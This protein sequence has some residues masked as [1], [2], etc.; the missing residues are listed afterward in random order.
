MEPR[1]PTRRTPDPERP[2]APSPLMPM[3]HREAGR[4]PSL[5]PMVLA[6]VVLVA[7]ALLAACQP[8]AASLAPERWDLSE[9]AETDYY[10]LLLQDA[11]TSQNATVGRFALEQLLE[12]DPSPDIYREGAEFLWKIGDEAA[13]RDLLERGLAKSPRNTE[14]QILLAQVHLTERRY[15]EAVDAI[16]GF[17]AANPEE[18]ELRRRLAT[19]LLQENRHKET[20]QVFETMAPSAY[21]TELKH[22][23]ARALSGVKRHAE[24]RV[25]LEEV[26]AAEPEFAEAHAELAFVLEEQGDLEAAAAQYARLLEFGEPNPELV[27]RLVELNL[28]LDREPRAREYIFESPPELAFYFPAL[29]AYVEAE[30]YEDAKTIVLELLKRAPD[31]NEL[32]FVHGVILFEGFQDAAGAAEALSKVE[33]G[34]AFHDRARRFEVQ[35]LFE[36]GQVEEALALGEQNRLDNEDDHEYWLAQARLLHGADR[37]AEAVA[38]AEKAVERWPRETDVLFTY[39]SLLDAAGDKSQAMEV[40]EVVITLDEDH[41]DA[42][43]YIGYTLA[44][45]GE[46]L[47]RALELIARAVALEPENGYILDSL[48]WV[49]YRI[50]NLDKAWELIQRSVTMAKDDPIIWE[51]YGDIAR[52]KNLPD[53]AAH[54]YRTALALLDQTAPDRKQEERRRLRDKLQ[55]LGAAPLSPETHNATHAP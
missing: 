35:L 19:L 20:L 54:G 41:A 26:L 3:H 39:G 25:L 16:A 31:Q 36:S 28:E 52:D 53:E 32:H 48:A 11:K 42:L 46:Q 50:G 2:H 17:L 55:T 23:K 9:D 37:T 34:A 15:Q 12:R 30:R 40:M 51:H 5:P 7:I 43:N 49:Q 14:L 27:K 47:D 21:D 13:T 44:D 6:L 29:T 24:A 4:R 22:L 45:N 10:Y 38:L 1:P 33:P 18:T 8:K